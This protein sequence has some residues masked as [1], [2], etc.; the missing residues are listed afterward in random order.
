VADQLSRRAL[1]RALL[2][3]QSLLRR[4]RLSAAQTLERLVG[5]QAQEPG[6]PYIGLWTRLDGFR[7]DKLAT[8]IS[9]RRAVRASLMRGTIHLVTAGDALKL[10][11]LIQPVFERTF[12]SGGAFGRRIEGVNI[13]QLLAAIRALVEGQPRTAVELRQALGERWPDHDGAALAYAAYL[14]P[15]VQVPPRGIWGKSGRATWTTIESWLGRPLEPHPGPDEMVMRYLAAFGPAAAVDVQTWSG[16]TRLREVVERLGPR[17]RTF[18]DEQGKELFDL[19]RGP[20]PDPDTP[21]PPRFLPQYDN[22]LLSHADRSR[23]I[24]DEYR[25]GGIG[26]PTVL[27]DGFVRGAWRIKRDRGDATLLIHPFDRLSKKDTAAV[28]REGAR[29]LAFAAGDAEVRDVQLASG[30]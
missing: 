17:L 12:Y 21:A 3:R 8:L 4:R 29:L 10:R 20:R 25:P 2:E 7:P 27:I 19:P 15:L 14:I 6:D 9:Q 5:M 11:P 22:L 26:R 24:A 1:N 16:L 13:E 30:S 28:T 18:R 23:I